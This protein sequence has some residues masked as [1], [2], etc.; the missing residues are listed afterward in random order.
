MSDALAQN[1]NPDDEID[2]KDLLNTS[3]NFGL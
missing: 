2:P 1:H 3:W